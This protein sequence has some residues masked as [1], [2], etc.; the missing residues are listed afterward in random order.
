MFHFGAY[1]PTQYRPSEMPMA[2]KPIEINVINTA[3]RR[4]SL[5][6]MFDQMY[7]ITRSSIMM[8]NSAKR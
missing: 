6:I 7:C 2:I 3:L 8:P 4:C 1:M 5:G